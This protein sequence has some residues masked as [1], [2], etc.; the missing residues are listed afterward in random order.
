M[1]QGPLSLLLGIE[2]RFSLYIPLRQQKGERT[3]DHV[4]IG[5]ELLQFRDEEVQFVMTLLDLAV[6]ETYSSSRQCSDEQQNCMNSVTP[7]PPFLD[8]F[9]ST[10]GTPVLRTL[11][12][13]T[14]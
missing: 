12:Q 13:S 5:T 11:D 9:F 4:P 10:Y 1:L 14:T 2:A 7:E 8:F 3:W 6:A